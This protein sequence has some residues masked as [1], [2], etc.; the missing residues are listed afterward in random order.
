[1]AHAT[2]ICHIKLPSSWT[3]CEIIDDN[4]EFIMGKKAPFWNPTYMYFFLPF[5][6]WIY[7]IIHMTKTLTLHIPKIWVSCFGFF[8]F[9]FHAPDFACHAKIHSFKLLIDDDDVYFHFQPV[10]DKITHIFLF[11]RDNSLKETDFIWR[12]FFF[13]SNAK[14]HSISIF[15]REW[16]LNVKC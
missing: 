7:I 1:M 2:A 8:P 9:L 5:F 3:N 13:L 16:N 10:T 15:A 12:N 14:I 6:F 4:T 11:S